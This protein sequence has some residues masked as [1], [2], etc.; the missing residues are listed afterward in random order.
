MI[1]I[2]KEFGSHIVN[3]IEAKSN[4]MTR[5]PKPYLPIQHQVKNSDIQL[6]T[7]YNALCMGFEKSVVYFARVPL[8]AQSRNS[9]ISSGV[10]KPLPK[11]SLVCQ[12]DQPKAFQ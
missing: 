4:I 3:N 7:R 12:S 6:P 8:Q 10:P 2:S 9:I 1:I 5:I 11:T